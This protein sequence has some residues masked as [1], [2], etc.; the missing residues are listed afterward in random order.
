[1]RR[2]ALRRRAVVSLAMLISDDDPQSNNVFQ[3]RKSA[4]AVTS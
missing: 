3:G 4:A 2:Q 1:M